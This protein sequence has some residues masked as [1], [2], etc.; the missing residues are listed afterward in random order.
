[1]PSFEGRVAVVTGAANGIGQA[2]AR[3]FASRGASVLLA[4]IDVERGEAAAA[5]PW[6]T[7]P[8]RH[9]TGGSR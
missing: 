2:V 3:A 5:P 6:W 7:C 4:D 9:G 1:M 8:R